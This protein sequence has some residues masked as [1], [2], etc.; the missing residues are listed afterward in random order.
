MRQHYIVYR[1]TESKTKLYL[2]GHRRSKES[3]SGFEVQ[4]STDPKRAILFGVERNA[5]ARAKELS[6]A[7]ET[8]HVEPCVVTSKV[9]DVVDDSDEKKAALPKEAEA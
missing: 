3:F 5:H 6:S 7:I 8:Y 4:T 9:A 2:T 1:E